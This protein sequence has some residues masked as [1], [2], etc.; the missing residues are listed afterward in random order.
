MKLGLFV[1]TYKRNPNNVAASIWIR[2]LQMVPTYKS[3]G[4]G[5]SVNNIFRKYD[6]VIFYRSVSW[7]VPYFLLLLRVISRKVYF[8]TCVNYLDAQG[9]VSE[10]QVVLMNKILSHVDGVITA[11][12]YIA[13]RYKEHGASVFCMHDPIDIGVFS[14]NK[15]E[16]SWKNPKYIWSGVS[17]KFSPVQKYAK[18][19]K[20]SLL[21]ISD[22]QV[23]YPY[24]YTH[25]K[26]RHEN[27]ARDCVSGDIALLPRDTQNK[28]DQGHSSFK[29]L[30]F[31]S[32]GL[33]ILAN[34]LPS[35]ERLSSFYEGIVFLEDHQ[36]FQD[37]L[38]ELRSRDRSAEEVRHEYCLETQVE[39]LLQYLNSHEEKN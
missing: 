28:Y 11:S 5:V 21:V 19:I 18:N 22:S 4:V 12:D 3:V 7:W 31:A 35:Y 16:I 36:T 32:Q 38:L 20:E 24:V 14:N 26:W 10:K 29:A 34:R 1:P 33:P 13:N 23:E 37:A 17:V 9:P 6:A 15:K 2:V 39:R 30:V 25:I 8:D 27:F